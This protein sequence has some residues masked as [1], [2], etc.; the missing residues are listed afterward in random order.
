[1]KG[2]LYLVCHFGFVFLI[3]GFFGFLRHAETINLKQVQ[4]LLLINTQLFT[5]N[6]FRSTVYS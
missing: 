2:A 4:H 5:W 6:H 1:M 3:L